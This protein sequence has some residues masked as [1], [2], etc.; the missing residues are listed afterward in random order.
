MLMP[1][2][3]P[4]WLNL[5][6]SFIDIDQLLYFLKQQE[7]SGFLHSVYSDIQ[8][9]IFLNEG[10][11]VAGLKEIKGFKESGH[12]KVVDIQEDIRNESD[13]LIS[14]YQLSPAAISFFS[15]VFGQPITQIH[16]DLS[17]EFTNLGKFIEKILKEKKSGY[18][19][20]R[21]VKKSR[22]VFVLLED[23]E[24][25]GLISN[26]FEIGIEKKTNTEQ[27][28]INLFSKKAHKMKALYDYF[29]L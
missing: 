29:A 14:V 26:V 7:F 5:R 9:L 27:R 11:A 4:I 25:R 6:Q 16:R 1:K 18:M 23:G 15:Y 12:Q 20:I 10:D 19:E 13:G 8:S 28:L 3:N 21:F 17:S 2:G 22:R 24:I